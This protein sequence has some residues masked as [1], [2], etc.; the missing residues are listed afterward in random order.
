MM[1]KDGVMHLH[2]PFLLIW[3]GKKCYCMALV[4]R[5]LFLCVPLLAVDR[6]LVSYVNIIRS[7]CYL[8]GV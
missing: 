7:L 2:M 1:P 8:T 3:Q 6:M 4:P 5:F